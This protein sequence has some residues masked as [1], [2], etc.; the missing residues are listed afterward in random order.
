[1]KVRVVVT[2][3]LAVLMLAAFVGC[4][5]D[6]Q[7]TDATPEIRAALSNV[8]NSIVDGDDSAAQ[9]ALA[10]LRTLVIDARAAGRISDDQ[11][12]EILTATRQLTNAVSTAEVDDSPSP[13]PSRTPMTEPGDG[14]DKDKRDDHQGEGKPDHDEKSDEHPGNSENAPGHQDD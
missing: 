5:N 14:K 2:A 9:K 10:E 11:A 3:T 6:S 1:M 4:G 13:I 12:R 7:S 8:E